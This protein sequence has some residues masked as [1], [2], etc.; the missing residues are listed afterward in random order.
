ML[1]FL[2]GREG[3]IGGLLPLDLVALCSSDDHQGNSGRELSIARQ[4]RSA[5]CQAAKLT[6]WAVVASRDKGLIIVSAAG[7]QH[8]TMAMVRSR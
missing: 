5:Y 4:I 6:D 2:P 3:E 8:R 1:L 7:A